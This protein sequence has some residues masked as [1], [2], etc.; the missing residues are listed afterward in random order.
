MSFNAW[1]EA[2]ITS[3]VRE[4]RPLYEVARPGPKTA[5]KRKPKATGRSSS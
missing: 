2:A 1:V 3:V 5:V 4:T